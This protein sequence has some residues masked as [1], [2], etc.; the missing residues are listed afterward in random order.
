MKP[1][2]IERKK[3]A[4][5]AAFFFALAIAFSAPTGAEAYQSV[6]NYVSNGHGYLNASYLVIHETAN[7]GASAYNHTL[8]WARDDTYAVHHVMELD[9][10]I[11]YNTVPENRLCWHVGNGNGYT[12]GIEL[13]HATDAA[14]FA[15]QWGEAVKWTGDELRAHGWDTSRLLSHY[16]AARRWGGSD[17][18]DPNGYFRAYGKTWL[19]FKQAVSAYLGSGYVAPIAPTDGNGGTYRPSTSAA[20]SSFPKSTGKSVNIHYALHNSYGSWNGAVTNFNDSNS[21]GFAG[22]PYGSHDMLIAWTDTGTL[23]YR[24]HTEESGWLGWVQTAN[25]N[26]SVNGMAGIWGQ[27]IDGVQMYYIT[28]NGDYRQVYYRSQDVAHAGYWDEVCDDG[29]TYGGDDYAGMY[30]YA[31]DRLQCYVSDGTRR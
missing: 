12:I 6:D 17:H 15:K 28:P 25:Y 27:T 31:L 9:G 21:E 4:A 2:R 10:S 13:A 23:R 14:D 30:G 29:S 3:G 20:R 22:A 26:D 8:L 5:S 24:V 16:E 11:V 7:P 18:T 19:E 1:N